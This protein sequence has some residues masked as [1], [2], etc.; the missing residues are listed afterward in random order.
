MFNFLKKKVNSHNKNSLI[1][2]TSNGETL[3]NSKTDV[4]FGA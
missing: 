2:L 3:I 4:F 1:L